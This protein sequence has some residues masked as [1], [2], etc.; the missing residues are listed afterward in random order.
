MV[1]KSHEVSHKNSKILIRCAKC[2]TRST[3]LNFGTM[4]F[5]AVLFLFAM[6]L[7]QVYAAPPSVSFD[8]PGGYTFNDPAF[9]TVDDS[10]NPVWVNG[11]I[12]VIPVTVTA[13]DSGGN[14]VDSQQIT[15]TET[16]PNTG[17]FK[18]TILYFATGAPNIP[19]DRTIT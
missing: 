16:G 9:I 7:Q 8:Q 11:I 1:H 10:T 13:V 12:D 18:N 6:S 4:S 14:T 3:I 5:F 2:V 17:V 15:L 19:I